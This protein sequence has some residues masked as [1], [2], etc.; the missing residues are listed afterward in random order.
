MVNFGLDYDDTFTA[1]PVLW[2]A[3]IDLARQRGHVV[4]IT[5]ARKPNN[6]ADIEKAL[7]DLEIIPSDGKPKAKAVEAAGV[8]VD[9]W[10]DDMPQ[11][12]ME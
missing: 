10:I 6:I 5:T 9:I 7:P 3:F 4:F 1:D 12:I 2:R 11:I 8:S